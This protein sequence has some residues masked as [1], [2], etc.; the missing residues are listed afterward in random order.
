MFEL[1]RR[2]VGL[3]SYHVLLLQLLG[4]EAVPLLGL[5]VAVLQIRFWQFRIKHFIYTPN[6]GR[7]F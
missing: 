5:L 6:D 2:D 4:P 3:H 1:G 7:L